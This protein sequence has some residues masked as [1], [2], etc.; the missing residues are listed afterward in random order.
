MTALPFHPSN[1]YTIQ[2]LHGQPRTTCFRDVDEAH[3]PTSS[4]ARPTLNLTGQDLVDG[5]DRGGPGRHRRLRRRHCTTTSREAAADPGRPRHAAPAYFSLSVYPTSRARQPGADPE[6]G[7]SRPCWRPAPVSSSCFCGPCFGAG[8]RARQQR[9]AP[10]ATPP[11]TSPTGRGPSPATGQ[12]SGVVPH[13]RPVHRR[14]RPQRRRAH[15]RH[16][17]S[18]TPSPTTGKRTF[19]DEASTTAGC[20]SASASPSPSAELMFGPNI[21]DWPKHAR[22]GG[23]PA[24]AGGRPCCGTPSPPPTSS[25]PP[26]RPPPTAPTP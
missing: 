18:A 12:L 17:A 11:G 21:A 2:E 3:A 26:A 25:S 14:H 20:T 24:D 13:G 19:D 9:P 6:R 22:P 10:S 5:E 16:R 8:R 1:A 23:Q 15:R 4:A 7:Y